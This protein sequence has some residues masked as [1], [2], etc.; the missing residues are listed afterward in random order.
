MM[1]PERSRYAAEL[2]RCYAMIRSMRARRAIIVVAIH[3]HFRLT[4]PVAALRARCYAEPFII[5]Y[6]ARLCDIAQPY[7]EFYLFDAY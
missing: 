7:I 1:T 4:M 3:Y 5:E 6:G 2:R